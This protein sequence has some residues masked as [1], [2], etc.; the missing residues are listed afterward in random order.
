[1]I[2][3]AYTWTFQKMYQRVLNSLGRMRNGSKPS[4]MSTFLFAA[5]NVMNM[6]IFFGNALSISHC[7]HPKK[8]LGRKM[9]MDL[10]R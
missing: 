10:R 6:G 7:H 5:V 9:Q 2:G 4:T 8:I 1:M 3:S